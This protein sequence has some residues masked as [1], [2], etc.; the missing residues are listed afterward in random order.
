[1][2]GSQKILKP[3]S[4]RLIVHYGVL[5]YVLN[6]VPGSVYQVARLNKMEPKRKQLP[7]I[8]EGRDMKVSLVTWIRP[9]A[10]RTSLR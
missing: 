3:N 1:M 6:N 7:A 5:S 8:Y 9:E 4:D 2:T 10:G